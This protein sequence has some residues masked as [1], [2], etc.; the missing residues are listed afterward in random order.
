MYPNVEKC[1]IAGVCVLKNVNLALCG[2]KSANPME[3]SIK[4]LRVHIS[5]KKT[6]R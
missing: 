1:E 6:R 3:Y 4:I 2:I 5:Y